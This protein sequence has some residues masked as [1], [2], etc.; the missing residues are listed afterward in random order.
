MPLGIRLAMPCAGYPTIMRLFKPKGF[1][2]IELLVVVAIIGI[3]A[4]IAI[5]NLILAIERSKQR[6]TMADIRAIAIAWESRNIDTGRY[7]AAGGVDGVDIQ[8]SEPVLTGALTPTYIK[9]MP[10][11]DGWGNPYAFF[12]NSAWGSTIPASRYAIISGGHDGVISPA[13]FTGAF[14]NYDCDIVYTQGAF[15]SYP[16]GY[17]LK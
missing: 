15:L 1:T 2:L 12:T 14:T 17:G 4:A 11:A 3:L 5:P 7:N 8:V 16:E 13:V 6:R 10:K 9:S